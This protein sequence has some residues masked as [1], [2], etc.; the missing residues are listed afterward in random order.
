LLIF[1]QTNH[2]NSGHPCSTLVLSFAL[3]HQNHLQEDRKHAPGP[4]ALPIIGNLPM[5]GK[6]PHRTLQALAKPY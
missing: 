5:L 1:H 4:K 6:L 2:K 3:I